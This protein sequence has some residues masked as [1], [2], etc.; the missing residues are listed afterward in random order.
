M[1]EGWDNFLWVPCLTEKSMDEIFVHIWVREPV[2][3]LLFWWL[4]C[5]FCRLW[6]R[7]KRQPVRGGFWAGAIA[8][9]VDAAL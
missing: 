3:Y 5:E 1:T 7:D 9:L 2:W 8:L 4:P 6:R